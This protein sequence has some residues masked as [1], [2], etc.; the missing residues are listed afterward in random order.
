MKWTS[1][2]KGGTVSGG[3]STGPHRPRGGGREE[4]PIVKKTFD[5]D[6]GG[7]ETYEH[8]PSRKRTAEGAGVPREAST[9]LVRLWQPSWWE[10]KS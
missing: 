6:P 7:K 9:R 5:T 8:F 3:V 2:L 4:V 1:T 10:K